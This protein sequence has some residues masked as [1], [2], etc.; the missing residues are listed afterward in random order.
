MEIFDSL[1]TN[2]DETLVLILGFFDGLH[3]GHKN[4]IKTGIEYAQ[5]NNYKSALITFKESPAV[6]L[7]NKNLN[8]ILTNEEKINNLEKNGIDYLY[9]IEFNEN[10]SK[11][12]AA[13]YLKMLVDTF[14]PKAII[15]GDNHYFGH[16]R[17]GSSD[18]L[19]IMQGKYGY[20]YFR[21]DT[22]KTEAATISSSKIRSALENGDIKL[23]NFMLGYRFYVKGEVIKGRQIG[24]S[25][26]FKTA[27]INYPEQI[28]KIPDGVYATEVEANGAKYM[29][30]A[31]YGSDPTISENGKKLIEV[32][33]L[34][35]N[36]DIYGQT[37]KISFLDKIRDEKK[38]QSL[39]EL[40][41]QITKDIKCLE[42]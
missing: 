32:H 38:F 1:K 41:E 8:Y 18:F 17:T 3:L 11:M 27:N 16:N 5:N 13:D 37:I 4:V 2:K 22:V 6:I 12:T 23:A 29:G 15:S 42:S 28:I 34:N 9:L 39:T 14:H 35:F 25:I 21:V 19:E 31:N 20:K 7:K 30:I 36:E 24:R 10:L 26:G 33:I 40:K